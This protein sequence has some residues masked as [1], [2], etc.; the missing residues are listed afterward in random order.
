MRGSFWLR[1]GLLLSETPKI[2]R[3]VDFVRMVAEDFNVEAPSIVVGDLEKVKEKCGAEANGCYN[4]PD[5]QIVLYKDAGL[6]TLLHE[7]CHHLQYVRSG[8]KYGEAFKNFE[9]PH[10]TRPHEVEA[11]SFAYAYELF[12]R[13]RFREMGLE[14]GFE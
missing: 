14:H 11:K 8:E 13:G 9:Q 12:Y 1:R 5:K 2:C 10:C 3:L 4:Y 7:F 6:E